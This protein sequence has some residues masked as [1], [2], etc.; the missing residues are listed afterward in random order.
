MLIFFS[1]ARSL[2]TIKID[3]IIENV[4]PKKTIY[5]LLNCRIGEVHFNEI[6]SSIFFVYQLQEEKNA[7]KT[8]YFWSGKNRIW[9]GKSQGILSLTESGH[10]IKFHHI[11]SYRIDF[12]ASV[13]THRSDFYQRGLPFKL[14]SLPSQGVPTF[15]WN[16]PYLRLRHSGILG[17]SM[18]GTICQAI[19]KIFGVVDLT[20]EPNRRTDKEGIW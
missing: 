7:V 15:N 9:S 19:C 12:L 18:R 14:F 8:Q 13:T 5:F 2:D 17:K 6:E 16:S 3:V 11:S 10:P 20:A 4:C 1:L